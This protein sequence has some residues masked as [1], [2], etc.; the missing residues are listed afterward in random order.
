M[1]VLF[2]FER[3]QKIFDVGGVKLGGQPGELPTVLAGSVFHKGHKIVQDREHGV[4]NEK[5]AEHLINLQQEIADDTGVPCMLDVVGETVEALTKYIDFVAELTDVP[6]LIN[7]QETKVRTAAAKHAAEIGLKERVVYNSINY[8]L[9]EEEIEAI[10]ETEVEA[11]I[12]Q[13]FNPRNPLPK[14]MIQLL[15]GNSEKLGLLERASEAGIKKPLILTPVLDVPSLGFAAKGIQLIKREFGLP[16]GT[17]PVGVVG[18]W[19]KVRSLGKYARRVCRGGA[20][21]LTQTM[22]SDYIIYGS[23]AKARNIFPVCAMID[24]ITAYNARTHGIR[25]LTKKHPLYRIF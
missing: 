2:K 9:H 11:A 20:T 14:G 22:G 25:P 7:G 6:L 15:K 16:T 12:V 10:R 19:E 4:F 17:A 21:T 24:A 3:K 23:A 8:T 5:K 1:V 18:R 13:A